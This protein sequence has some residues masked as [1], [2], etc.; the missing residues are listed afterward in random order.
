MA[1]TIAATG[2]LA[3]DEQIMLGTEVVGRLA[4][5]S[6]D[7]GSPVRKGQRVARIDPK[8]YQFRLDQS[9]ARSPA[10]ARPARP[11][12]GRYRRS[13]GPGAD[14][15]G[16]PGESAARPGPAHP[17]PDGPAVRRELIRGPTSTPRSR[18]WVAEGRHQEA[19][20]T[21]R[22][23]Q[24][25][26]AQRKSELAI[27]RQQLGDT[28][29][30]APF[31]GV[32][33]E[34]TASVGDYMAPGLAVVIVRVHP[35]RLRLSVPEREAPGPPSAC[36]CSWAW[37][38]MRPIPAGWPGPRRSPS[39]A[40][41]C[42]SRPRCPIRT[43]ALRPALRQGRDRGRSRTRARPVP[44]SA[45]VTFA[46]VEKVLGSRTARARRGADHGPP[47]GRPGRDRRGGQGRGAGGAPAGQH[48]RRQTV[49][50]WRS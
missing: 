13:G 35:L 10:G 1:R 30:T 39:R 5:I 49:S 15:R 14:R 44:A 41:R 9:V 18:R 33:S 16:T 31:D 2:T 34:R 12:G 38:V 48:H 32:I 20:E 25:L 11:R 8:D 50:R 19:I 42:W 22:T 45:I 7:L 3:A 36:P 40:A 43:G 37:R 28:A 4:E 21:A 47:A 17:R 23:R 29:L 24:G 46:G 6:V 26:L 27:A